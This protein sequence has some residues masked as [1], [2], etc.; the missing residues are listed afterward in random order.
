[1]PK[2]K[3]QPGPQAAA[4]WLQ[5]ALGLEDWELRVACGPKPPGQFANQVAQ[6]E[7]LSSREVLGHC[8]ADPLYKTADIWIKDK[9]DISTLGHEMCHVVAADLGIDDDTEPHCEFMWNKLGEIFAAAYG[10]KSK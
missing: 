6:D 7:V 5:V 2:R 3:P 1:M 9:A 8:A 10:A 4:K